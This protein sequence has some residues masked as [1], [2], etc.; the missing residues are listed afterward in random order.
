[1]NRL[2]INSPIKIFLALLVLNI[3][4]IRIHGNTDIPSSYSWNGL[5]TDVVQ[6]SY[7]IYEEVW[8]GGTGYLHIKANGPGVY[9][10][11][12]TATATITV[13][14]GSQAII[15]VCGD[16]RRT[17]P[18]GWIVEDKYLSL[19]VDGKKVY[20]LG[21]EY[22]W[23]K[24]RSKAATIGPGTHTVKLTIHISVNVLS[25]VNEERDIAYAT[26]D[27]FIE[28]SGSIQAESHRAQASLDREA[29]HIFSFKIPEASGT[30]SISW[31]AVWKNIEKSG[32][33]APGSLQEVSFTGG[34]KDSW[35]FTNPVV[36]KMGGPVP[37]VQPTEGYSIDAVFHEGSENVGIRKI[38]VAVNNGEDVGFTSGGYLVTRMEY[39][40]FY[41]TDCT[42][43]EGSD[44]WAN[45]GSS[46][47]WVQKIR[48]YDASGWVTE[49]AARGVETGSCILKK[50][51]G[52]SF[53][54]KITFSSKNR[55]DEIMLSIDLP[56][57][58]LHFDSMRA[59][60]VGPTDLGL[61][62][63]GEIVELKVKTFD[64][65][66]EYSRIDVYKVSET[67]PGV[68]SYTY[69][70]LTGVYKGIT[71]VVGGNV[72]FTVRWVS[73]KIIISAVS[74]AVLK[75]GAY[76]AK[77]GSVVN[78]V[79][80]ASFS[81]DGSPAKGVRIRDSEGK[82]VLTSSD[83]TA[84]FS[85]V[86]SDCESYF[87]Y[88]AVDEHGN[89]SNEVG[90]RIIFSRILVKIIRYEGVLLGGTH[91]VCNDAC[92]SIELEAVYSHNHAPVSGAMIRFKPAGLSTSTNFQGIAILKLMDRNKAYEG[93]IEVSDSIVDGSI[94]LRIVFTNIVLEPSGNIFHGTPGG[95][96]EVTILARLT[97]NN[98]LLEGVKVRYVEKDL[99][100]ETPASFK[101]K[102]PENG[103]LKARFEAVGFLPCVK[104]C[105]II[106]SANA[107]KFSDLSEMKPTVIINGFLSREYSYDFMLNIMDLLNLT[108]P[109]VVWYGNGS[110]AYGVKIGVVSSNGTIIRTG[111]V[112]ERGLSFNWTESKPGIYHYLVKPLGKDICGDVLSIKAIFTAFN[113]TGDY[114]IDFND[115]HVFFATAR[116]AHNNSPVENLPVHTVIFKRRVLS[117]E[118][119]VIKIVLRDSDYNTSCIE[120]IIVLRSDTHRS[121]IWRTISECSVKII[122][123]EWNNVLITGDQYG[124]NIVLNLK[125]WDYNFPISVRVEG[126]PPELFSSIRVLRV[127]S[128]NSSMAV[129][130]K[131]L[132]DISL[133]EMLALRIEEAEYDGANVRVKVRSLSHNLFIRN[134][135]V[136]L[137]NSTLEK[138]I[139]NLPPGAYSEMILEIPDRF[140]TNPIIIVACSENT[141][142]HI[143][144]VW[145]KREFNILIPISVIPLLVA[146]AL[147]LKNRG[148]ENSSMEKANSIVKDDE[149]KTQ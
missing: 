61:R 108:I 1:M 96:V 16:D 126:Y 40:G 127:K 49:D 130:I 148:S 41:S 119:G 87:S 73:F 17:L 18:G 138:N 4:F 55:I 67:S 128:N 121:G 19:Y 53:S 101:I 125:G 13:P 82:E 60:P 45:S 115:D 74:G 11:T 36:I 3:F 109:K 75:D 113:I 80:S 122:K 112:S 66:E 110:I 146:L 92:A 10:D 14:Q 35:I 8:S 129:F 102:I 33:G 104:P 142:P 118:N 107:V 47:Q 32:S 141:L 22:W 21:K 143:V 15:Y 139:D 98:A 84:V 50:V 37:S 132:E 120:K 100:K 2:K 9:S 12:K 103:F 149:K 117:D 134:V 147:R 131:P 24:C 28:K 27:I 78:I 62:R 111:V 140:R 56:Q 39:L 63:V 97:F 79:I 93:Y 23:S 46:V 136:K 106:V 124:L 51:G 64:C 68:K 31:R 95:E 94:I 29:I 99:I 42:H 69:N 20:G 30:T 123:L 116:W 43:V 25:N 88:V 77:S 81:D 86:K 7:S 85:Y 34:N 54:K 133:Q 144:K 26:M 105:E 58:T 52:G 90:V 135:K 70:P 6:I 83:G 59:E 145:R 5:R 71:S 57:V 44:A 91:Y 76:W 114:I 38:A 65:L 137:L 48:F 72:T 89:L